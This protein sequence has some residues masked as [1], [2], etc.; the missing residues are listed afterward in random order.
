MSDIK[1][2]LGKKIK[3]I[4][5]ERNLTQEQLAERV[6]IGTPN[7]SYIETGKFAPSIETMQKIAAALNV[8]PRELYDF[9]DFRNINDIKKELFDALE[10]D[11]KAL[12]IMYEIFLL[13]KFHLK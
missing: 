13:L 5:K 8:T 12:K 3:M 11:E 7:I 4:R 6:D 10:K 9:D 1:K 2:M